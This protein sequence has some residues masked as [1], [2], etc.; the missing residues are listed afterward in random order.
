MPERPCRRGRGLVGRIEGPPLAAGYSPV[1]LAFRRNEGHAIDGEIAVVGGE[2]DRAFMAS[3]EE[4][5]TGVGVVHFGGI[6]LHERE[7]LYRCRILD[8]HALDQF[9]EAVERESL[10]P[11]QIRGL[12]HRRTGDD[13]IAASGKN[14][15]RSPSV[16]RVEA[17]AHRDQRAGIKYYG[18]RGCGHE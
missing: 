11:N 17:I 5:R 7:N 18:R 6:T 14:L 13:K 4:H 16:V 9:T 12:G 10:I 2:H 15:P 1:K 8:L 3:G